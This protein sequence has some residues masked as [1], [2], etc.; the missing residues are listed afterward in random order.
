MA[1]L[2]LDENMALVVESELRARGHF[3]TSTYTEGRTGAPDSLLLL[4]AAERDWTLVTHNRHDF[5]ML[6]ETWL[7]WGHAWGVRRPQAGILVLD[8]VRGQHAVETARLIDV[9]AN[10][11][12]TD[13]KNGLYDWSDRGG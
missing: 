9:V 3:V 7:R 10:D 6:H 2:Y 1:A 8:R 4:E 5:R 13:L 11:P 12:T